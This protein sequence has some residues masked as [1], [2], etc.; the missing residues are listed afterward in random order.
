MFDEGL[1]AVRGVLATAGMKLPSTQRGAI[2][3]YLWSRLSLRLRGYE[4]RERPPEQISSAELQR[5]DLCWSVAGCLAVVDTVRAT[6]FQSKH[7]ELAL[8]A[9]EP[10][11]MARALSLEAGLVAA[12]GGRS[13]SAAQIAARAN[14]LA[15][16]VNQPYALAWARGSLGVARSTDVG[17]RASSIARR[18]RRSS[19]PTAAA[20]PG[21]WPPSSC[22]P[23]HA[24]IIWAAL[25]SSHGACRPVCARRTSAA[26]CIWRI[27]IGPSPAS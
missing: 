18:R 22:S 23:F 24:S 5:I 27:A 16:R 12:S 10:F 7:L 19:A 11:R 4:F 2:A 9:G 21:S 14:E 25:P 1:D 20:S 26:I 6:Q 15:A 17:A 8:A 13:K 3:S